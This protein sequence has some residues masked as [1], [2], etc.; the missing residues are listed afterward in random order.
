MGG[1]VTGEGTLVLRLSTQTA[2]VARVIVAGAV[3]LLAV[4]ILRR[5]SG[6]YPPFAEE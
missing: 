6:G 4:W 2:V 5:E 3:I 1:P